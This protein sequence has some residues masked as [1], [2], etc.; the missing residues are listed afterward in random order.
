MEGFSALREFEITD[1]RDNPLVLATSSWAIMSL[2]TKRPVRIDTVVRDLPIIDC[3]ALSVDF[4][5]LPRLE[6]FDIEMSYNVRP[7][8]LD[9]NLHVNHTVYAGW[10]LETVPD[11]ILDCFNP[12]EI[13]ISYHAEAFRGDTIVAR[14]RQIDISDFPLFL[15]QLL[16]QKDGRELTRLKTAWRTADAGR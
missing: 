16:N 15:H 8:D 4:K 1:E 14:S 6:D 3:R 9:L 13:E 7:A 10:A 11:E 2:E 12:S 5:S